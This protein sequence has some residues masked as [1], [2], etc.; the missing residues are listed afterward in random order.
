MAKE[1]KFKN[2]VNNAYAVKTV[3][4]ISPS[5]VVHMMVGAAQGYAGWLFFSIAFLRYIINAI[6]N[7]AP[8]GTIM[9]F[10]G[11]SCAAF[12]AF[13][14]LNNY[15]EAYV[16]PFTDNLIYRKLY[17]KLYAKARNVE[18]R[19]FEDAEFYNRYTMAL[20]DAPNRMTTS[21]HCFF[22]I[23]FGVAAAVAAFYAIFRIDAYS[24]LF[25]IAPVVGNFVLGG[26]MNK[27]Y[28]KRYQD[29]VKH[30]RAM[31]YV[32]RVMY[33]AEF[34]KEIRFS[35]VFGLMMG[36]SRSAVKGLQKVTGDY[37]PKMVV[38][39]W[40]KNAA[41]FTLPFE[42]V[43]IYAAY[44]TIVSRTMNLAD[45]AIMLSAMTTFSWIL[46]G[47]VDN[48][49]N[50]LKN[51]VF[52]EY[53]RGFME[54]EEKIAEDQDGI[55]PERS[56]R[57]IEFRNV[58][59][60][61]GNNTPVVKNLSF[62]ISG[63]EVAALVGHNGAGKTTIIKL[64]FRLY[65]PT[66][67]EIL[68]NGINVKEYNVK[69]YRKMFA[70]AFQDY[71]VMSMPIR[72]NVAMGAEID[73]E[74]VENAL[75]RAGVWEKV[76]SLPKGM[77]TVLTKEFEED[78]AVLS[79]GEYQKIIVARAFAQN[80]PVKVFDEPSS[81]LDPIAEYDLYKSIME[82]SVGKT[83]IFISHRLSSVKDADKV[84]MLENGEII[85]R[86]TH[87]ELMALGGAYC[88]MFT[89]QAQNYMLGGAK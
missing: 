67:G 72:D 57:E 20:D 44:R 41:V 78:G 85:E 23:S 62:S 8:F 81:A 68:V 34:A 6:Q 14:M 17:E 25:V 29:S 66:E 24:V 15:Q 64:L 82:E 18:L 86:G 42:G 55:M 32:N 61:Y 39:N 27:L 89:K 60:A 16:F 74:A 47:L 43:M 28:G 1:S 13:Y 69:A 2:L 65:D 5:R 30:F 45:L 71:K 19:C 59:F 9:A 80:A 48:V 56:I 11:I 87:K 35:N 3:W 51:G 73:G 46:I 12:G 10:I 36:R 53:F 63:N 21:V 4:N 77:D 58:G 83:T 76:S 54:Y 33:L 52:L 79:G 75:R 38:Y 37:A 26:M 49:L 31:S 50:A 40:I 84:F 7:E 70:A 88:E 22:Q